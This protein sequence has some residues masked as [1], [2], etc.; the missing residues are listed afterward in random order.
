MVRGQAYG[1][2]VNVFLASIARFAKL[3]EDA[4]IILRQNAYQYIKLLALMV[5]TGLPELRSISDLDY[6]RDAL[7]LETSESEAREHFRAK[8]QEARDNAWSTSLNWFFHGLAKET[9]E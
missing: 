4:Y 6:V 9:G 8:L 7:V 3:C 2:V 1:T 5:Q